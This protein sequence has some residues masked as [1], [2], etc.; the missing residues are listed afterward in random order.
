MFGDSENDDDLIYDKTI[1]RKKTK[2]NKTETFE[3]LSEKRLQLQRELQEITTSLKEEKDHSNKEE[4]QDSLD[5]FMS[6]IE[7]NNMEMTR[8]ALEKRLPGLK[9][10]LDKIEKLL[11]IVRPSTLVSSSLN[12][13]HVQSIEQNKKSSLDFKMPLPVIKSPQKAAE[14]KFDESHKSSNLPEHIQE[15]GIKKQVRQYGA[16]TLHESDM[17]DAKYNETEDVEEAPDLD[18]RKKSEILDQNA[19]YGY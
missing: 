10:E 11:E 14:D 16:M 15:E 7:S 17:H 13:V 18:Y 3:S 1:K 5:A 4:E 19:A 8:L 9:Q 12:Q 2:E 6:N